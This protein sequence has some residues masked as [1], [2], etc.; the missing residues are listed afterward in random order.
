MRRWRTI[1]DQLRQGSVVVRLQTRPDPDGGSIMAT[2]QRSKSKNGRAKQ[3]VPAAGRFA[4][5]LST[6]KYSALNMTAVVAT[7]G[8]VLLYLLA[9]K[10]FS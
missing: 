5:V 2:K 10:R 7:S 3:T 6:A 9:A 1:E 4:I 8:S